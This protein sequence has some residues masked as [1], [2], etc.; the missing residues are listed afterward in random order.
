MGKV[1]PKDEQKSTLKSW[2]DADDI[3][4]DIAE[5]DSNIKIRTAEMN[6]KINEIQSKEQPAID[7]LNEKKLSLETNLKL[8]CTEKRGDFDL[9]KSK[10]LSYGIVSFRNSTGALQPLKGFTWKSIENII[11]KMKK[12]KDDFLKK[13]T[14]IDKD[15]IKNA[16][17]K[18]SE[19]A[20]IG[21]HI[22]QE[23]NFYYEIHE[24]Q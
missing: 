20:K 22:H 15:A 8:F 17:L 14:K 7:K 10:N 16:N 2:E 12:Y 18:E 5:V 23:E 3:L 19:L 6:K 11:E 9:T 1:K 21:L 13:T 4:K 24:R